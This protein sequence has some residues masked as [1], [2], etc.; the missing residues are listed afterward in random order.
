MSYP[1][2]YK[3]KEKRQPK[4]RLSKLSESWI[5]YINE[6]NQIKGLN[7]IRLRPALKQAF[8]GLLRFPAFPFLKFGDPA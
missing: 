2:F 6:A 5:I 1:F 8:D 3:L 7:A 4:D